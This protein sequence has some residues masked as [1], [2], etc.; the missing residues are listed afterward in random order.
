M[1]GVTAM[2][3]FLADK[4]SRLMAGLAL[5]LIIL[6]LAAFFL[7]LIFWPRPLIPDVPVSSGLPNVYHYKYSD[8]DLKSVTAEYLELSDSQ[9]EALLSYL[10][11]CTAG[12]PLKVAYPLL[13][14][15]DSILITYLD[16][17]ILLSPYRGRH[18]PSFMVDGNTWYDIKN[19]SEV[20]LET[21]RILGLLNIP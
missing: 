3:K 18:F 13:L 4:T 1:K 2:K 6:L 11:T 15:P 9:G 16:R 14:M 7:A 19:S 20:F 10:R 17:Q 12:R 8:A 21:A 5:P